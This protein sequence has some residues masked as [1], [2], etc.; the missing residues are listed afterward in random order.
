MAGIRC[1]KTNMKYT[2]Q[3][4]CAL[5]VLG[6]VSPALVLAVGLYNPLGAQTLPQIVGRTIQFVL[7]ASGVIAL[8]M[9]LKGGITWLFAKGES[10]K[11]KEGMSTLLWACVGLLVIFGSYSISKF[12]IENLG[13]ISGQQ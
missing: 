2:K 3:I 7:G 9:I 11:I 13:R 6:A 12:I 5:G 1:H 8:V 10:G 4:V